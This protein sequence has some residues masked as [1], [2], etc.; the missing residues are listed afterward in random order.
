MM[1][2]WFRPPFSC[3]YIMFTDLSYFFIFF[4][5][6]TYS[7][8][9]NVYVTCTYTFVI[10]CISPSQFLR[11]SY[12]YRIFVFFCGTSIH[13]QQNYFFYFCIISSNTEL[14]LL[15]VQQIYPPCYPSISCLL[16]RCYERVLWTPVLGW[17]WHMQFFLSHSKK[18]QKTFCVIFPIVYGFCSKT[19]CGIPAFKG[20]YSYK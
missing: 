11:I 17:K 2:S 3:I 16:S 20:H 5:D 9:A 10:E 18:R 15:F 1:C 19:A 13:S 7:R 12:M 6:L 14:K 8:R 4:W